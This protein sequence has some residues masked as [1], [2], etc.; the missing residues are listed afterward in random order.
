MLNDNQLLANDIKEKIKNIKIN[1]LNSQNE[2]EE[3]EIN[4]NRDML[5]QYKKSK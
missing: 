4:I 5:N 2:K 1:K 3:V